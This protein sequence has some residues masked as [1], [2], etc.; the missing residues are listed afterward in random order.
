MGKASRRDRKEEARRKERGR[1]AGAYSADVP[2][3][4]VRVEYRSALE[5]LIC[6]QDFAHVPCVHGLVV[7]PGIPE[8]PVH[9]CN[10]PGNASEH[11]SNR[12][13]RSPR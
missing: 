5:H 12:E 3:R 8:H 4:E 2:C 11:G 9:V 1:K 7:R 13:E 10:L 6:A